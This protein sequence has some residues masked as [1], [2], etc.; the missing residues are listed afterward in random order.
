MHVML[1]LET[2]SLR[3]DATIL[4]IAMVEFEPVHGGHI[5]TGR[6]LNLYVSPDGQARHVCGETLLW[7]MGHSE[8]ARTTL[9]NGITGNGLALNRALELTGAWLGEYL[10]PD[11][12][13]W[14]NGAGFDLPILKHAFQCDG[15]WGREAPWNYRMERDMRTRLDLADWDVA[16]KAK[17]QERV[18]AHVLGVPL[19]THDAAHDA[20]FQAVFQAACLQEVMGRCGW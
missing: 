4:Q 1:D 19:L 9:I 5:R 7:W 8:A 16:R 17:V 14:S 11:D 12:R 13:I 6:M 3:P 18:E 2:L 15:R 10:G 20:V